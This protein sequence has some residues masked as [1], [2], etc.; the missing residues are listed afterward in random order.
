MQKDADT[1]VS[2]NDRAFISQ[3][4]PSLPVALSFNS[5]PHPLLICIALLMQALAEEQRIDGR[6]PYDLRPREFQVAVYYRRC[7]VFNPIS[8][9]LCVPS[10]LKQATHRQAEPLMVM[11]LTDWR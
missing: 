11:F 7:Q 2:H 10:S 4:R 6:R 9:C 8:S 5:R 3:V 1:F